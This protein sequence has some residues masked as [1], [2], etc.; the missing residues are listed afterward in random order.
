FF[1]L[2]NSMNHALAGAMRGR[3][4]SRGPMMAMLAAFV[5]FRQIYLFVSY[6]LGGGLLAV[7]LGY[8]AGWITC[9]AALLI[10]VHFGKNAMRSLVAEG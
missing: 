2:F 8:P 9:C 10:Y 1:I 6:R 7:T 3:G 4:D 5:V